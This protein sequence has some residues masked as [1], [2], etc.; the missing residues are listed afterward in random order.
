V[1]LKLIKP[2]GLDT[3]KANAQELQEPKN[4]QIRSAVVSDS[5]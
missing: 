2:E 3:N 1:A 4:N 5:K